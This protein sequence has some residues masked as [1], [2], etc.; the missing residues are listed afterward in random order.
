MTVPVIYINMN[1][2][3]VRPKCNLIH[4][5]GKDKGQCAVVDEII[6]NCTGF[7]STIQLVLSL[8]C[9]KG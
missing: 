5:D 2:M 6:C 7:D 9:V 8:L 3:D 1:V 4:E